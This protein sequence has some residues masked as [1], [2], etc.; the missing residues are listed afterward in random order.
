RVQSFDGPRHS[1]AQLENDSLGELLADALDPLESLVVPAG[2]GA[3]YLL[4]AQRRQCR[5]CDGRPN[6]R[7]G[8]E[9]AEEIPL[10]S[11]GEAEQLQV[12]F[13]NVQVREERRL[14]RPPEL[15]VRRRRG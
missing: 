10:A 9:Q 15:L 6:S 7:D 4:G 5:Q 11:S 14:P 3:S 12:V 2:D 8:Q 1:I 13:A